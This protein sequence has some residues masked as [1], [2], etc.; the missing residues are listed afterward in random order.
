MESGELFTLN[1]DS[2]NNTD[3]RW[4][5]EQNTIPITEDMVY[6]GMPKKGKSQKAAA[7]FIQWFFQIE[8]QRQLL[9]FSRANRINESVFGICGG[10]SVLSPVTEQ[11]FPRFYPQ[12]LGRMPPSEFLVPPNI[13][14][15]N[16]AAI[17]ERVIL[18]YLNERARNENAGLYPLD[19]R[20]LDWLR[21]NR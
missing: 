4:L 5:M 12:L 16:W 21:L 20:L 13:V 17:K 18:P 9:E 15:A 8:S 10:F 7:A 2:M 3:F 6:L 19:R 11:I 1:E 14:P